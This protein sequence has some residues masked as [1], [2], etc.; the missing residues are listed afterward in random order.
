MRYQVNVAVL[1]HGQASRNA[2]SACPFFAL[3]PIKKGHAES[4]IHDACRT[5][6]GF[7]CNL[8]VNMDAARLH[9][10]LPMP[11]LKQKKKKK[12]KQ[13][14]SPLQFCAYM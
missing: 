6:S 5:S 8:I 2:D 4:A 10:A 3:T 14:R 7:H 9:E 12:K 13:K 11:P 1:A